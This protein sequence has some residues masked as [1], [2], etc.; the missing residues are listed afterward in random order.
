MNAFSGT[1]STATIA[2]QPTDIGNTILCNFGEIEVL[3]P[4]RIEVR[5]WSFTGRF[6]VPDSLDIDAI[7]AVIDRKDW[8][9]DELN[10]A[11]AAMCAAED[12]LNE[13]EGE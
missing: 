5:E 12:K 6:Y 8:T 1:I 2:Q 11:V 10:A 7:K 4:T 9:E 13:Q 3:S